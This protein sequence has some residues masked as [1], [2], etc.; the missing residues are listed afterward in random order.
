VQA[1]FKLPQ[2][3]TTNKQHPQLFSPSMRT[4][5][6]SCS[7]SRPAH[8]WRDQTPQTLPVLHEAAELAPNEKPL[9][10]AS[11][12]AKVEIF[13]LTCSLWHA[14]QNTPLTWL[15]LRTNSSNTF[16]QS[17]QINSNSGIDSSKKS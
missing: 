3:S 4:V 15:A 14:G 13:F 6:G 7:N 10:P 11:L 17:S 1:V 5:G 8:G 9:P 16:P 2:K 12:D